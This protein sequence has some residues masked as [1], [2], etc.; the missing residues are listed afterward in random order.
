[1]FKQ[2]L[3]HV[4]TN[5]HPTERLPNNLNMSFAYIEGESLLMGIS[6]EVAVSMGSA[7]ASGSHE[8]SHVL[9]ALGLEGYLVHSAIR[10]GLGRFNTK[11]EVAYVLRRVTD[12]VKRLRTM[13]LLY[14]EITKGGTK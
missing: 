11:E 5:G 14:Q 8:L 13:S 10:F 1:G 3:D 9:K 7:C 6:N 4:Y 12:E 2:E